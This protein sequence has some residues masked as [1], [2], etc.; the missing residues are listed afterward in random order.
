MMAEFLQYDLE[1]LVDPQVGA[2]LLQEV[3]IHI[4][5]KH[6]EWLIKTWIGLSY[7]A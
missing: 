3:Q 4:F 6:N 7:C 5:I 2:L 1:R